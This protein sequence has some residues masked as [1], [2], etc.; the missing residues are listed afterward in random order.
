MQKIATIIII[1]VFTLTACNQAKDSS[2]ETDGANIPAQT[3]SAM[4]MQ[5]PVL[6]PTPTVL[7][8]QE[9]KNGEIHVSCRNNLSDA[10]AIN[11]AIQASAYG[12][13]I[14]ISG[15]CLINQSIVLLGDRSYRGTST[16][17]TVLKQADGANLE[18]LLVSDS[19]AE[20]QEW[21]GTPVSI[22]QMLLDGNSQMNPQAQTDGII[23][24]SWLSVVEYVEITDM[25]QDGIKLAY[26]SA[27][28]TD[29]KGGQVNGRISGNLIDR[30]GRYGIFVEFH[31]TDWNLI[32]NWIAYSGVDGLHMEDV[33]G[34]VIERNHI[35]G[36]PHTAI[37]AD[38]MYATSISDNY[39]EGFGETDE[40][41]NGTAFTRPFRHTPVQP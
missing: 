21:T 34:W 36:V 9:A 19:Y 8:P 7:P 16:T 29:L 41:A 17:G 38:H 14:I 28:G 6:L 27:N 15:Q 4:P 5:A 10:A 18:A 32:D 2:S 11:D 1:A 40:E 39:I 20:N 23:L 13:E 12:D 22:R 24:R 25:S 30:S 33:S 37:Y 3:P 35:Y 31:V 26:K